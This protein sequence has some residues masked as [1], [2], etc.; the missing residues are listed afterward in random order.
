MTPMIY[1]REPQWNVCSFIAKLGKAILITVHT[2]WQGVNNCA[3]LVVSGAC[4]L[5]LSIFS[6]VTHYLFNTR[7][8]KGF[9]LQ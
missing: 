5:N 1:V 2:L 7:C 6:A 9:L 3:I 4:H 8:I